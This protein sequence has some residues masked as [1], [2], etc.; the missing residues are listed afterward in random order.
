MCWLA[1]GVSYTLGKHFKD[2]G[3]GLWNNW[4]QATPFLAKVA[5]LINWIITK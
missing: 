4:H 1:L 2:E 5:N 3:V